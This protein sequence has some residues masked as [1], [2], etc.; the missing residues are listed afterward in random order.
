MQTTWKKIASNFKKHCKCPKNEIIGFSWEPGVIVCRQK[1]S[2]HFLQTFR[3]LR[4]F[5]IVFRE[6]SFYPKQLPLFCLLRLISK[7]ADR[8]DNITTYCSMIEL[9]HKLKLSS[10]CIE[11]VRH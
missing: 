9:L 1:P 5:K 4:M 11:P 8:I 2:N 10:F 7:R 6:I 3:P